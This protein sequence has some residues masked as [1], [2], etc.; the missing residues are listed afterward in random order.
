MLSFKG[1]EGNKMEGVTENQ[2]ILILTY[3]IDEWFKKRHSD[4]ETHKLFREAARKMRASQQ[5]FKLN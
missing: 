2:Q 3:F 1:L 4:E 5:L